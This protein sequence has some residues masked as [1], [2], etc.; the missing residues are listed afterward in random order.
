MSQENGPVEMH[1]GSTGCSSNNPFAAALLAAHTPVPSGSVSPS[2]NSVISDNDGQSRNGGGNDG[3]QRSSRN[4]SDD[5]LISLNDESGDSSTPAV[6]T[7]HIVTPETT[8]T[9]PS[10]RTSNSA[11]N[12]GTARTTNF[13]GHEVPFIEETDVPDIL[14]PSYEE[15]VHSNEA[16]LEEGPRPFRRPPRPNHRPNEQS[17]RTTYSRPLQPPRPHQQQQQ[18][19]LR[20]RQERQEERQ[21]RRLQRH[22]QGNPSGYHPENI[23]GSFPQSSRNTSPQYQGH[24][25]FQGPGRENRITTNTPWVYPPDYFCWKCDNTGIKKKNGL[26]CKDCWE[27][28]AGRSRNIGIVTSVPATG[29]G[30]GPIIFKAGDPNIGGI[31]CGRCRGAGYIEYFLFQDTC[32]ICAGLGRVKFK[33]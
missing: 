19:R 14:P 11:N 27:M 18:P 16:P 22:N 30:N 7:E 31:Q 6:N 10:S 24:G 2:I 28:F 25:Q 23:P 32:P 15:A 3:Q 26:Q 5:N 20:R 33:G 9:V 13:N 12:N 8:S 21:D 17:P 1:Q 29:R 4:S